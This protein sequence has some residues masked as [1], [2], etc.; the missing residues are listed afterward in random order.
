[1]QYYINNFNSFEKKIVYDFKLGN[2]GIGDS[3][4]FFMY[5]LDNCIKN[6]E[7]LYYKK[8]N[9]LIE[10]YIKLKYPFMYINQSMIDHNQSLIDHDSWTFVHPGL[11]YGTFNTNYSIDIKDVFY[12]TD[13]VKLN[14]S[15][16]FP[17]IVTDYVSIHL[18]LGDRF[19]ETDQS[20]V[21]CTHDQRH[22]SEECLYNL[23][24]KNYNEN[25]FFCCD[26]AAFKLKLQIKYNKLIMTTCRIGHSSLNNTTK[27]QVL[28]AITEF[29]ILTNSK[30]IYGASQS[31]FSLLA[32]KFNNVPYIQSIN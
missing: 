1:M 8:N 15:H 31:G 5:I 23:I 20:F 30:I 16:I 6:N 11:Y 9:L 25:I 12:F 24:E 18:R 19:L 28:D 14:A 10:K 29:Y 7:R 32:S 27:H 4:K 22:F 2:G 26:N 21:L 17:K 13:K 3:L